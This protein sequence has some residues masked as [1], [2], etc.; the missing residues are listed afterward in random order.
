LSRKKPLRLF[1][2]SNVLTDGILYDYLRGYLIRMS[3]LREHPADILLLIRRYYPFIEFQEGASE[4]Q[5]AN[6]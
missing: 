4:L 5:H 1:L 2:D 3:A 6:R